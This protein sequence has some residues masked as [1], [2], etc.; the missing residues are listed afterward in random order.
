MCGILGGINV[1]AME[2]RLQFILHRGPDSNGSQ[3][4]CNDFHLIHLLHTRL[5]ILDLSEAGHQ[6]MMTSDGRGCIVFNGEIYNHDDI[7]SEISGVSFKGHSDTETI[8]NHFRQFGILNTLEKLNGIFALAYFD[9]EANQLYLARDRFGIKPVY[10]FFRDNRLMFSSEIRPLLSDLDTYDEGAFFNCLRMR[11]NPAPNTIYEGIHKV[12]PGEVITIDLSTSKLTLKK[13][14][15]V[16]K[17]RIG[18]R[19]GEKKQL[20]NE[21]GNLFE[22]AVTRQLMADVEVGILLSGGIDSALV[23]AIAKQHMK[24]PLKAFTIGFDNGEHQSDEVE[25]AAETA[26]VLRLDHFSQRIRFSD[27]LASFRKIVR[28]VEEPIATTS[29]IPM[30]E[31]SRLAASK[32]KVVLSGQGA[33]E[34]LGGYKKYRGLIALEKMRNVVPLVILTEHLGHLCK[35]REKLYRMF[36]AMHAK[37]QIDSYLAY[38]EIIPMEAATNLINS[39]RQKEVLSK[40]DKQFKL[41]K[42]V[43][44]KRFPDDTSLRYIFPFYDTRTSLADDLL[45]YTD[46]LTMHFGMEC[47]VPILDNDLMEFIESLKS[48]YKF[49]SVQG[50]IIHKEFARQY[51]PSSIIRRKKLGFQSPTE[52]W[53]RKHQMELK[54]LFQCGIK[55]KS[56]FNISAIHE[57]ID[58]HVGGKN[59]EKQIFI[60]LSIFFLMENDY[61]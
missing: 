55:F 16:R 11:Y 61:E 44:E 18:Y 26:Q 4:F 28:I 57:F 51:L 46:K 5:S 1:P 50:K 59:H 7:K 31:L 40:Y 52:F 34:S 23:G 22:K 21:Y 6:P 38:N 43:L 14:Y 12:E 3:M 53:F 20:V 10:Y 15:F 24:L 35:S 27:F 58:A 9:I 13:K 8:V 48:S 49:N 36:L 37:T 33:D 60:L 41:M 2:N 45:M 19:G 54:N 30:F 29:I 32:V 47:R 56:L 25:R 17:S 42:T 39:G